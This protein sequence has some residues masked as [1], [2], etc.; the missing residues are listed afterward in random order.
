MPPTTMPPAATLADE[1]AA[2]DVPV[3]PDLADAAALDRAVRA[4]AAARPVA[5]LEADLAAGRIPA[6]EAADRIT[7]TATAVL[8]AERAGIIARDLAP[9][10]ARRARAAF[11]ASGDAIV[12]A[13]QTAFDRAVA[14]VIEAAAILGPSPDERRVLDLGPT[15]LDAWHAR[16]AAA[17]HLRK[18]HRTRQRLADAGYGTTSDG[19]VDALAYLGPATPADAID[20]ARRAYRAPGLGVLN[21]AERGFALHLNTAAEA[22]ALADAERA[23][24]QAAEAARRSAAVA[25]HP[26]NRRP[27]AH[28]AALRASTPTT[29][30]RGR[31]RG[32]AADA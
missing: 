20:A 28:L 9:V 2:L 27:L 11:A 21:L 30:R 19:L 12:E 1:L 25:A 4:A 31:A 15:A 17:E 8:A 24:H 29:P 16:Q 5:Q 18:L 6:A 14:A 10:V 22:A 7:A 23:A 3:P 26:D 13:L 32:G